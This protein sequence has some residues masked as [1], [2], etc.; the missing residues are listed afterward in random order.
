MNGL[1]PRWLVPVAMISPGSRV[2]TED[3]HS[4]QRGILCAMSLVLKFCIKV[5][6][7]DSRICSFCGSGIS[8]LVTIHG[9]IGAKVSRD[10]MAK[11]PGAG[12]PRAEPSIKQV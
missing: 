1:R 11:K 2:W 3:S 4:M 9:P 8:S 7:F 12:R 10:F 5:P 6:L